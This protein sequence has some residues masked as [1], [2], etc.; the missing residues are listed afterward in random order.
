[1]VIV[2]LQ[3]GVPHCS[4]VVLDAASGGTPVIVSQPSLP[5]RWVE[6]FGAGEVFDS[7]SADSLAAAF[8]RLDLPAAR[9]G[10]L[11]LR[12]AMV[13]EAMARR[14]LEAFA[15]LGRDDQRH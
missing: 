10:M 6:E 2:S 5:A 1:M 12:D 9:T 7:G 13:G 15:V 3:P 4:S 14:Y 8:D 11:A